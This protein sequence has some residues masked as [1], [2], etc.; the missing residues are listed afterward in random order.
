MIKPTMLAV[1]DYA[2]LGQA[3]KLNIMGIF[4]VIHLK[5]F[6]ATHEQMF[7]VARFV[8]DSKE[9]NKEHNFVFQL[10]DERDGA[11]LISIN[12][13]AKLG[14]PEG[15][16]YLGFNSTVALRNIEFKH[17]GVYQVTIIIDGKT[18]MSVPLTLV[19]IQS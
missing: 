15:L 13:Q 19:Q 5:E 16:E 8:A 7:I 18:G 2:S 14:K 9:F 6:P 11:E 12:G 1:A 3:E 10:I 17:P 4:D